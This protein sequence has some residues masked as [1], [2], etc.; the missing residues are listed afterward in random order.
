[1]CALPLHEVLLEIDTPQDLSVSPVV[2][3]LPLDKEP[4]APENSI[5]L[6]PEQQKLA[7]EH[8]SIAH[9]VAHTLRKEGKPWDF[10]EMVGYGLEALCKAVCNFDPDRGLEFGAYAFSFIRHRIIDGVRSYDKSRNGKV[11]SISVMNGSADSLDVPQVEGGTTFADKLPAKQPLTEDEILERV[12]AETERQT[13]VDALTLLDAREYHIIRELSR[14]RTRASIA[15][16]LNITGSRISQLLPGILNFLRH[17]FNLESDIS[18]TDSI[19]SL[20]Q[21]APNQTITL[22]PSVETMPLEESTEATDQA[23]IRRCMEHLRRKGLIKQETVAAQT[24]DKITD[25]GT[26]IRLVKPRTAEEV[27]NEFEM[28]KTDIDLEYYSAPA[29]KRQLSIGEEVVPHLFAVGSLKSHLRAHEALLAANTAIPAKLRD[30]AYVCR[31]AVRV[32]RYRSALADAED[33]LH[34][35]ELKRAIQNPTRVYPLSRYTQPAINSN[36]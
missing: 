6:T 18:T 17:Q 5:H 29:D 4:A 9:H 28:P 20:L 13:L 26:L 24:A 10:D 21:S 3:E 22:Y 8:I 23:V 1:M 19:K 34:Q 36:S 27:T 25:Y 12:E 7:E 31:L 16:E 11:R 32:E 2:S 15:S 35:A 30:K 33:R 14:G